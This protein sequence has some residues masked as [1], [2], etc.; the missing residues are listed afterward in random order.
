MKKILPFI[1]AAMI[2]AGCTANESTEVT[3]TSGTSSTE[4]SAEKS[5]T[6]AYQHILQKSWKTQK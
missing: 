1:L 6:D 2:L 4:T 5:E 3:E